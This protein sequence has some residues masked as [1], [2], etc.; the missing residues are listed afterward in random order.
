ME[1]FKKS[2]LVGRIAGVEIRLHISMLLIILVAYYLFRP[3]DMAGIFESILWLAGILVCVF[4]HEVGH[5]LMARGLGISVKSIVMWP[6]GGVTNLSRPPEKPLHDLLISA[7]GPLVNAVIA[8]GLWKLLSYSLLLY[9]FEPYLPEP[10]LAWASSIYFFVSLMAIMNGVLAVFNLLP[11]YPLDGGTILNS[12]LELLFGKSNANLV[13]FIIGIPVLLF[14]IIF[15]IFLRDYILLAF[16]ILFALGIGSLNSQTM[17]WINLGLNY[18][19]N[20][21]AYY[22]LQGDFDTAIEVFTRSL[23]RNPLQINH[24]LGRSFCYVNIL[25]FDQALADIEKILQVNPNHA[26]AIALRGER[27]LQQKEYQAALEC[28]NRAIELKPREFAIYLDRGQVFFE[29]GD[30]ARGLDEINRGISLNKAFPLSFFIRSR[31]S[32]RMGNLEASRSDLETALRLSKKIALVKESYNLDSYKEHLDWANSYYGWALEKFPKLGFAYQGRGD[33]N[34]VNDRFAEAMEDY[35]RAIELMP[36]EAIL[37]LRRGRAYAALG[38][39][40]PAAEDFQQVE[41]LTKLSHL[42]RWAKEALAAL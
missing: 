16:C 32:Y 27:Y 19:L 35:T 10:G 3:S 40:Q 8:F 5:T 36:R 30:A 11:L 1:W 25:Q 31:V 2:W 41:K 6:L 23:T 17:R 28:F 9:Q 21:G 38:Q 26:I 18:C 22:Y 13:S 39:P 20:R 24:Y 37:Y 12:A 14:V 33:A 34:F 7:A 42:R 29:Q 15:G 4:L